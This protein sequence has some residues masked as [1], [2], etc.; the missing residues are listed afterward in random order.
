MHLG[1]IP[2]TP[3]EWKALAT[4]QVPVPFLETH[5]AFGLA[6]AVMTATKLGVFEAL[7]TA[8]ATPVEVADRCRTD[9]AATEKLLIAL[10]GSGYLCFRA[11]RYALTPTARSWLLA[12][13]PRS[14]VDSVLFAFDEWDLMG[15]VEDYVRTGKSCELHEHIAD[16]QWDIYQRSM[17][18][19]SDQFAHEAA[20]DIPVPFGATDMIDVGGS[21][22][23]YSVALCRRNPLLH[24]VV[25]DLPEAGRVAAPLLAAEQMGSRIVHLEADALAHDFGIET[26]DVVLLSNL[27]HHFSATQN[28]DLC[29]RL[30]QALRPRGVF[31]VIEPI[32]PETLDD[33]N[34]FTGLNELYFGLT[35]R[36][37]T[38]TAGD[39]AGWQRD[40]GLRPT[41]KPITLSGSDIGLQ[42]AVKI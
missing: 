1:L 5:F 12:A 33:I 35:S 30:G 39:I 22:G 29:G 15:R 21:H 32:R 10:T 41:S 4:G 40:A 7:A 25:L 2:D 3:A 13:S 9:S 37:G 23:Q 34:Q 8:A 14:I 18:A 19:L 42:I 16:E 24:S 20:Q 38:W 11:G 36:S 31:A 28:A 26:Y 6:R 27:A 17:R